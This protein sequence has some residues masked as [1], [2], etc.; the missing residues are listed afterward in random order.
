MN[1]NFP[2]KQ[3]GAALVVSLVLLLVLTIIA[4]V[5]MSTATLEL[6]MAGNMQYQNSAFEAAE[7]IVEAELTRNDLVPL[8][9][10][11]TMPI[12]AANSNR[13]FRDPDNDWVATA[14][15]TTNYLGLT[16]VTGWQ[17]GG[18]TSFAAFHF[19]T[20]GVATA[21]KGAA[22]SHRQGYYVVGPS[23]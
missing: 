4:V 19:E 23:L 15:A 2:N 10:P 1:R 20:N 18:S 9:A 13:D 11:G 5:G 14:T 12:I 22:A 17:L 7:S 16:G 3:R 8:N 21:A 6:A